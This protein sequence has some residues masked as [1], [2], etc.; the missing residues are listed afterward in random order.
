MELMLLFTQMEQASMKISNIFDVEMRFVFSV[1]SRT[2]ASVVAVCSMGGFETDREKTN[3][4]LFWIW[5]DY[6][7]YS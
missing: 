6:C 1:L 3:P 7:N 2:F 4:I 5:T